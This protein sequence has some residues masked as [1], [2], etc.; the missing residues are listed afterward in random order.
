[1]ITPALRL[2]TGKTVHHRYSP[3][4]RR[5]CY[6][7]CLIDMDID[8]LEEASQQTPL[9]AV[10][11]PALFSF[12]PE[13][14]GP[15]DKHASLRG[16]AEDMYRTANVDLEGGPI[17]LITFARHLFYKFAPLS[18]WYGYDPEGNL[19]GIIYEV[20]NTFGERHCYVAAIDKRRSQHEADKSFHVSPF[21]DVAGK[22][23]FTLRA[24]DNR[25][26][27]TVENWDNG[28]RTHMANIVAEQAPVKSSTFLR[29]AIAQPLSSVGVMA[30]IHWQ[31]MKVWMRGAGYHRKPA[32]PERAATVA[33]PLASTASLHGG[34]RQ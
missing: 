28:A 33:L 31:A 25:L 16:W 18:L 8:K 17:R 11:R 22:Y 23:L 34:E 9:F 6:D 24:P 10:G 2:W 19:K 1:M 15:R 3:F 5:F 7:I 14:N 12:K 13:D 20:N 21:M 27:L 29:L 26:L 4:E 32:P 30:A